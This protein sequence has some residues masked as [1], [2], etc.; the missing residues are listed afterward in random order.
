MRMTE[1]VNHKTWRGNNS[2]W[3]KNKWANQILAYYY[4]SYT[5]Y[6]R[7]NI[8]TWWLLVKKFFMDSLFVQHQFVSSSSLV[9]SFTYW[10][11]HEIKLDPRNHY[12][13]TAVYHVFLCNSL[14]ILNS[15]TV[16]LQY[17]PAHSLQQSASIW[18]SYPSSVEALSEADMKRELGMKDEGNLRDSGWRREG[19]CLWWVWDKNSSQAQEMREARWRKALHKMLCLMLKG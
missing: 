1:F 7:F 18:D 17:L 19:L 12:V 2:V 5:I 4:V 15:K 9:Q 13:E 8:L 10:T 11:T 14:Q 6:F 3:R 16:P